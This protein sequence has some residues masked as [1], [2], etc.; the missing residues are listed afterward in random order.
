MK[1]EKGKV[2]VYTIIKRTEN[3]FGE[4]C[5][6]YISHYK[7][8]VTLF[9]SYRLIVSDRQLATGERIVKEF[10]GARL[11]MAVFALKDETL[12]YA[13]GFVQYLKRKGK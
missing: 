3:G 8:N 7:D 12:E 11:V 5:K 4:R 9:E 2:K 10:K 1:P 13:Y 6:T